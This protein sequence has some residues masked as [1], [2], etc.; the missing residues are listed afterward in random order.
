MVD[1]AIENG[2]DFFPAPGDWFAVI[3]YIS[4][5]VQLTLIEV[6]P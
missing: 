3:V 1:D 4:P 6:D 2:E 5:T